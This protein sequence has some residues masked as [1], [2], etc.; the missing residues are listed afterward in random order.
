MWIASPRIGMIVFSF[1]FASVPIS[2][3]LAQTTKTPRALEK[4]LV[5]KPTP[6][7]KV[8]LGLVRFRTVFLADRKYSILQ[9]P[10]GISGGTLVIRSSHQFEKW[11]PSK[12]V[13][14]KKDCKVFVAIQT[15]RNREMRVTD[16]LV[17]Q[18]N[19]AGWKAEKGKFT[20][21]SADQETWTW[22]VFS[23]DVKKGTVD[24]KTPIKSRTAFIFMF[25]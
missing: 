3:M 15:R 12:Q 9:L 24:L 7:S 10:R 21:T 14:A 11:L 2:P 8:Q 25:K 23:K 1:L 5:V 17:Q 18:M 16:G 22:A 19:D 13:V 20:T 4:R 6:N